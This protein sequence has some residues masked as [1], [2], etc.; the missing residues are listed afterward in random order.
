[1]AQEAHFTEHL[2]NLLQ[3]DYA[4]SVPDMDLLNILKVVLKEHDLNYPESFDED[5]LTI[6]RKELKTLMTRW[7]ELGSGQKL[8]LKLSI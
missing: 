7:D 2:V 6:I 1:M 3:I 8:K 4:Q 5:K